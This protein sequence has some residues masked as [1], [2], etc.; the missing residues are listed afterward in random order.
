MTARARIGRRLVLAAGAAFAARPAFAIDPGVATGGYHGGE[1]KFDVSHAVALAMDGA[2]DFGRDD[3]VRM[4]LVLSEAEV[5]PSA[6]AGLAFPPVWGQARAGRL[7]GLLLEFD[8]AD[9]TRL[10]AT[11]LAPPEPGYS[12]AT[13]T[14]SNSEGLWARLDASATRIAGELRPGVNDDMA[15][16]FSAPVF[17][18]PVVADLKGP[19]V[20]ASAPVQVM[21]ARA[22]AL[23]RGD[24]PAV[25]SLSTESAAANFTKLEPETIKLIKREMPGVIQKLKT[26][27]RVV[28]RRETAAV[29]L[30]KDS[31]AS[32][33]LVDGVWKGTD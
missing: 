4:R 16:S 20:Q 5:L 15:F 8:P 11:I 32:A 21:I 13:I 23:L 7:K 33:A 2:E 29:Q 10:T 17:T 1:G 27:K 28:I 14:L 22:E 19:A 30:D 26:A 24:I 12:L 9:R 25:I 18:N 3:H 6:L 31:W